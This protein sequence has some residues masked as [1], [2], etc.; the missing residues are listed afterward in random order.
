MAAIEEVL[1]SCLSVL[2]TAEEVLNKGS[3]LAR[4]FESVG[5]NFPAG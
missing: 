5:V 2:P 1:S 3:E 4:A